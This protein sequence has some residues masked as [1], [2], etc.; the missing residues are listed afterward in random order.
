M[1]GCTFIV[2]AE[3]LFELLMDGVTCGCGAVMP[4]TVAGSWVGVDVTMAVGVADVVIVGAIA[5]AT[6]VGLFE[7][8]IGVICI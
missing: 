6:I 4:I 7:S 1:V 3:L 2:I 8:T 5:P